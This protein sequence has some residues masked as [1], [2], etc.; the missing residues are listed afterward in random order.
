MRNLFP[1]DLVYIKKVKK[2][3]VNDAIKIDL[4]ITAIEH[5]AGKHSTMSS[6]PVPH[7]DV[8][9]NYFENKPG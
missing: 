3:T 5:S 6:L 7:M 1:D 2:G 9:D 4:T 8:I